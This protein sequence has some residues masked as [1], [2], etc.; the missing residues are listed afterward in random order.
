MAREKKTPTAAAEKAPA[1]APSKYALTAAVLRNETVPSGLKKL[2]KHARPAWD[3]LVV[4]AEK[5]GVAPE[6]LYKPRPKFRIK[7]MKGGRTRRVLTRKP[8]S[9]YPTEDPIRKRRS[10]HVT[11]K[12]HKRTFK[13]GLQPGRVLIVLAGRHKG[14]RVVV[15]KTLASGLILITGPHVINGCPI[16][17]MHQNFVIVTSTKLDLSGLQVPETIDDKY[18]KKVR[19]NL[20]NA[21]SK[22]AEGGDIFDTK[23]EAYKPSEQRKKDQIAVDKQVVE[24]IRKNAD[25]KLLFSYLGSYFQLRNRVYPHALKF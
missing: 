18:F 24:V 10:G 14:K 8:K 19:L 4:E 13:A 2:I 3:K 1:K 25:K 22:K 5:K 15:L 7:K 20:K 6:T 23:T 21:K 11:F 9:Y 12:T 16:R 17:R